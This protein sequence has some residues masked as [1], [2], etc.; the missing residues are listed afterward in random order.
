MLL[1]D[2]KKGT[3]ITLKAISE[4][5]DNQVWIKGDY[6]RESKTYSI[7]NFDDTNKERFIKSDKEVFTDFIF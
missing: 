3:Y 5:K 4:P 1:K 2:I 7:I 6:N